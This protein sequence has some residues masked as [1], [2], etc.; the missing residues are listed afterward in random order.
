MSRLWPSWKNLTALGHFAQGRQHPP[1]SVSS[2]H[3][4]PLVNPRTGQPTELMIQ[5]TSPAQVASSIK[6]AR[7]AQ[8]TWSQLPGSDRR[9]A[10]MALAQATLD[11]RDSLGDLERFETGKPLV[12]CIGE[13]D[14]AIACLRYF[15]GYADKPRGISQI[16]HGMHH[17]TQLEPIGVCGLITSFNYPLMLTGW[18]LA[19][20]LAAGNSVIL[21]PAPQTPL[22][23]LALAELSRAVGFADNVIQ[24]LPGGLDTGR[25]LVDGVDKTS[26]TGSTP[27][28]Q[29]IM[30]H[31]AARLQPL[32]LECGGK[33]TVIVAKDADLAAAAY[34]VSQGAFSNAGQNCCAASRVLVHSDVYD[35][36]IQ[37]LETETR[38]WKPVG[39]EQEGEDGYTYGPLIDQQQYDRVQSYLTTPGAAFRGQIE[40]TPSEGYFAPPTVYLNV[41]DDAPLAQDE[42]FG[43]VLSVLAPFDSIHDAVR[44]VNTSTPFGLAAGVFS[45]DYPTAH[46]VASQ[47]K[48]GIVWINT[49][50]AIPPSVPF[51][52]RKLSGF[53]KDL[54]QNALDEFSF[55]KSVLH[56]I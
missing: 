14:E 22:T 51:G 13:V 20:A 19:P 12:D 44:R 10:L 31:A 30:R 50:N 56:A 54:G 34:H 5:D 26:F 43:P 3:L 38:R 27:A 41:A 25:A 48:S 8:T 42:I 40:R 9:D 32:T 55:T 7:I 28:G 2:Q 29:A 18:K 53:G 4:R 24:V 11:H 35:Q 37:L 47:L 33:N 15:A 39:Q 36:F 52:G 17:T 1:S 49:Y 21:K 16:T 45:G 46:A 23:T 6:S